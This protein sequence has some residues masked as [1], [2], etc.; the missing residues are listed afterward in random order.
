LRLSSDFLVSKF[1]FK[2]ASY[3]YDPDLYGPFWICAT[4]IFLDAMVGGCIS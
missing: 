2:C 3:R 4:L 1:A